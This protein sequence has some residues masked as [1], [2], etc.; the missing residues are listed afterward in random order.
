MTET[1]AM[2]VEDVGVETLMMILMVTLTLAWRSYE[3]K[4]K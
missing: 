4:N 3:N 1:L 2:V